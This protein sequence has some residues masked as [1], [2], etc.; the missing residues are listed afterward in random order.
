MPA[1]KRK[2]RLNLKPYASKPGPAKGQKINKNEPKTSARPAASA[3]RSQLTNRD[4]LEIYAF[5]DAHPDMSQTDIV[6]HFGTKKDRALLF[7]QSTLSRKLKERPAVEAR[8]KTTPNALSMKRERLVT[9]PAVESALVKWCRSME[10]RGESYTGPMLV[11]KQKR[12]ENLLDIP[13]EERLRG[14]SWVQ[15]FCQAYVPSCSP[16][17]EL[18]STN[19][20][21]LSSY[22]LTEHRRHGEAG[23]VD[24]AAVE[25]ERDRIQRL[26][27]LE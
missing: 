13:L 21:L 8:A 27:L 11:E 9:Q 3:H 22:Q 25:V 16:S 19:S 10:E 17:T 5:I 23:S 26:L 2:P 14:T 6:A 4:W 15:S 24:V 7:T 20:G 1:D 12:F 18:W